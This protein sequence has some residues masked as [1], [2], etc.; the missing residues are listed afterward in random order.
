M[1][2]NSSGG[3]LQARADRFSQSVQLPIHFIPRKSVDPP[4]FV[5][6]LKKGGNS[7]SSPAALFLLGQPIPLMISISDSVW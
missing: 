3:S 7:S 4:I 6:S 5:N 2:V 1:V